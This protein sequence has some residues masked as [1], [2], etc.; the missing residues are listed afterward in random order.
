M[1]GRPC[2]SCSDPRRPEIDAALVA[3]QSFRVI[4]RQFAPLSH[5][6][7]RRHRPHIGKALVRAAERRG[8]RT[9]ET[10]LDKVRALEADAHRLKQKAEEQDDVRA[11]LVA[12]DK[13]LDVI[14]FQRE[15]M[16]RP[17]HD[18]RAVAERY[19]AAAGCSAD[20]LLELAERMAQDVDRKGSPDFGTLRAIESAAVAARELPAASPPAAPA[21]APPPAPFRMSV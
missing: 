5:D 12:V 19:A 21:D 7:I 11:A 4:A 3:G 18:L 13:L 6:A 16:P 2:A 14:R 20:E 8:E 15:L 9:D 10:L 17:A 1:S